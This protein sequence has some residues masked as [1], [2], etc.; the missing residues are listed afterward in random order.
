MRW[1]F[2]LLIV[3]A[4]AAV[5]IV[6]AIQLRVPIIYGDELGYI[7]NARYLALGGEQPARTYYPG[8]SIFLIPVWRIT[9][10]ALTV[11]RSAQGVNIAACL[12]TAA[13]AIAFAGICGADARHR[14]LVGVV[15]CIY[16]PVLL[17]SDVAL[18]ESLF[19]AVFIGLVLLVVLAVRQPD[20]RDRSARAWALA[21]LTAG[22]LPMVHPRGFAVDVALGLLAIATLRPIRGWIVEWVSL[23][24]G[25][26][27]G[28]A[29]LRVMTVATKASNVGGRVDYQVANVVGRNVG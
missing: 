22:L 25:L 19:Q 14:W 15:A 1:P 28:L 9:Q 10:H 26:T 20:V 3:G 27:T 7:E 13:E 16:P 5:H 24:A 21:G 11:W 12:V 18:A 2:A 17:Y 4:L 23:V 29:V 6:L 8:L